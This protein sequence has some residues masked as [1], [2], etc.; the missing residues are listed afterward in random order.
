V[1]IS[2]EKDGERLQGNTPRLTL[3]ENGTLQIADMKVRVCV[4]VRVGGAFIGKGLKRM[5]IESQPP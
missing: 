5:S 3:M 1:K 4:C 2:W